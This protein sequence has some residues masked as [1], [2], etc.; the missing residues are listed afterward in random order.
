MR[1]APFSALA[2]LLTA[3]VAQT[4]TGPNPPTVS[5]DFMVTAGQP[6][7]LTWSPTTSGP[8]TLTLRSGAASDLNTGTVIACVYL[9]HARHF[10]LRAS[11]HL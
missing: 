11:N 4:S 6:A 10:Q 2:C 1:L 8:V 9:L 5:S 7:T 3:V